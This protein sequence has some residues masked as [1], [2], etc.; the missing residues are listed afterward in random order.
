MISFVIK[1]K[2]KEKDFSCRQLAIKSQLGYNTVLNLANGTSRPR[3][4]VF[5]ELVHQLDLTPE[6]VMLCLAKYDE[7]LDDE[8]L[9]AILDEFYADDHLP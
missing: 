8:E 5:Q 3:F 9:M 7:E 2:L 6:E 4:D 1:R